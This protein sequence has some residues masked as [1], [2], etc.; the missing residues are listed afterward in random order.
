[1]T[2]PRR[3]VGTSLGLLFDLHF[4]SAS[5][6]PECLAVDK[7]LQR[8]FAADFRGKLLCLLNRGTSNSIGDCFLR[9]LKAVTRLQR[10][11]DVLQDG[12][13]DPPAL[14]HRNGIGRYNGHSATSI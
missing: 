13:L 10:I 8:C 4:H 6:L 14:D 5:D 1:M 11:V 7:G 2:H 9:N 12:S 3:K